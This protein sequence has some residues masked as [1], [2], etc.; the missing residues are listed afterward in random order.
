MVH[1]GFLRRLADMVSFFGVAEKEGRT[2]LVVDG[3]RSNVHCPDPRR[4]ALRS[5]DGLREFRAES[6]QGFWVSLQ[7]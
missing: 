6:L 7:F 2:R 5:G 1:A 4:V 3:R